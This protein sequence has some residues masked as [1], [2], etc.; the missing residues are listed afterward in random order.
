[1]YLLRDDVILASMVVLIN[2][3][4]LLIRTAHLAFVY[5]TISAVQSTD[6]LM[7]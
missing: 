2:P 3:R 5:S 1:M 4:A 7:F 6:Y